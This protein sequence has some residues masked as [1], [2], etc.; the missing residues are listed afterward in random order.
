MTDYLIIDVLKGEAV[1]QMMNLA[2]ADIVM[3]GRDWRF[4]LIECD[5]RLNLMNFTMNDLA[6][7]MERLK[8]RRNGG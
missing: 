5:D 1:V 8:I 4:V 7:G 6:P 3:K 2:W